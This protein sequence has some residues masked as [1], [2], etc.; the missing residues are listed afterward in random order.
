MKSSMK[1]I[2]RGL[3]TLSHGTPEENVKIFILRDI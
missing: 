3:T 1:I 2:S